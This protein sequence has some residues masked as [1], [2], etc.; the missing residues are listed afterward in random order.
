MTPHSL[1]NPP[2]IPLC[3]CVC[4]CG[5]ALGGLY[6]LGTREPLCRGGSGQRLPGPDCWLHCPTPHA[7]LH[8]QLS[9]QVEELWGVLHAQSQCQ[10]APRTLSLRRGDLARPPPSSALIVPPLPPACMDAGS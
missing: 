5:G 4:V 3:I 8:G 7:H 2:G 6:L 9:G 1:P 10:Q